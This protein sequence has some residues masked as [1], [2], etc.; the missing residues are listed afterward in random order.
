VAGLGT[1]GTLM[2][3]G[4]YLKEQNPDI[5]VWPSSRP[6]GEQVEGLRN[7]DEGYIPPVF[8]NWGGF[9]LLDGKR[10]VRPRESIEWTRRLVPSAASSPASP[11]ARR[12]PAP[13]RWPSEIE[14]GT[15]VFIVCDGGWKY[16]STGAYTDDLDAAE[17]RPRRSSTSDPEDAPAGP[18]VVEQVGASMERPQ[19]PPYEPPAPAWSPV[20][21][22]PVAPPEADELVAPDPVAIPDASSNEAPGSLTSNAF[23]CQSDCIVSALLRFDAIQPDL[24]FEIETNVAARTHVWIGTGSIIISNG[25]PVLPGVT[26][27]ASDG[28]GHQW[29]TTLTGLQHDTDYTVIVRATDQQG[30]QR[31]ALTQVRTIPAPG[32]GQLVAGGSGCYFGCI[33]TAFIA[34]ATY[35]RADIVVTTDTPAEIEVTVST[36]APGTIGDRPVLPADRPFQVTQANPKGIRGTA[37]Q[38]LPNTTYHVLVTAIDAEGGRSDGIGSF[39]TPALPPPPPPPVDVLINFN[40]FDIIYDGDPGSLNRG[41]ISLAWGMADGVYVG[42]RSEEKVDDNTT[43]QLPAGSG[44]WVTLGPDGMLPALVG[45]VAER[46]WHNDGLGSDI[47]ANGTSVVWNVT[48]NDPCDLWINLA[49]LPPQPLSFLDDLPYCTAFGYQDWRADHKCAVL[50]SYDMGERYATFRVVVS[51]LVGD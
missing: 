2:G 39:T 36:Q 20:A 10:I 44:R 7:L 19:H 8:E 50:G 37:S 9:E 24:G 46:D 26:P 34:S 43:I 33:E 27:V 45:N 49:E 51:F 23:G 22:D 29:S 21:L 40:R 6:L 32:G 35:D 47:C 4:R 42:H 48:H 18:P 30:T 17:S 1:S 41:E 13:P 31:Y 15:I 16:L 3:V 11:P 14:E 38:L 12:W 25:V 28:F 5:K